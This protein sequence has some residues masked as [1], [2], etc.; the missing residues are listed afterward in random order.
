MRRHASRPLKRRRKA[1][2]AFAIDGIRHNIPF[3]STLM[4]HPRWRDGALSTGFIAEE[5]PEGFI[6]PMPQGESRQASG[7]GCG[8]D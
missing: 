8:R 6:V 4:A 5:F 3:L 2:D 1:L 7:G